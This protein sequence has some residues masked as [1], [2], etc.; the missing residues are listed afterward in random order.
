M[1]GRRANG[2]PRTRKRLRWLAAALFVVIAFLYFK[3][4]RTYFETRDSLAGRAA[5]VRALATERAALRRRLAVRRSNEALIRAARRL[6]Y[7][8]PHERLFIV[9]GI[10][11][12][13]RHREAA[14]SARA[15]GRN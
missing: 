3:P 7:V 4:V 2:R 6:G 12:W 11:E 5:E 1:A 9:K 15:H 14:A 13:R 8:G 10:R